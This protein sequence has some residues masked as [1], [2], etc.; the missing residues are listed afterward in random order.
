MSY[1]AL[2]RELRFLLCNCGF[3]RIA[4]LHAQI[5]RDIPE[6]VLIVREF[7]TQMRMEYFPILKELMHKNN[8]GGKLLF[9]CSYS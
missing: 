5:F 9:F 1:N 7:V 4:R 6:V 2:R 3:R 8:R